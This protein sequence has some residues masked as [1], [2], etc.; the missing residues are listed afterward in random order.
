MAKALALRAEVLE[1]VEPRDELGAAS[2][3]EL[4]DG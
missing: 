4:P 2:V 3:D 1:L